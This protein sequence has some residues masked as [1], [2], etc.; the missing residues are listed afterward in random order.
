MRPATAVCCA[1]HQGHVGGERC[2]AERTI[3]GRQP[4]SAIPKSKAR[5]R[6]RPSP[7][8]ACTNISKAHAAQEMVNQTEK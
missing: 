3:R 4:T 2:I 5:T 1:L 6:V 8:A 7:M